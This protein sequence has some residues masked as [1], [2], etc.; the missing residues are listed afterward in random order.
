[1]KKIKIGNRFVGEGEPCFIVA[2]LSAN[3]NGS[4]S[5]AKQIIRLA[6]QA[7]ADAVKIQTY[8]PDTLTLNC[9]NRYF[10][11]K[12]GPWKGQNLYDLYTQAFMPW[13]WQPKLMT[14]ANSLGIMLFSTPFDKSAVD[15]L[16]D[17]LD[18]PAYKIAS[19]EIVDTPLI[20]YAA[21]KKKPMIISTGMADERE[22]QYALDA[23]NR[24]GNRQVVLL[25]CL[26]DYPAKP[27]EMN[28][29]VIPIMKKKFGMPVGLSDHSMFNEVALGA[30]SLGACMIE[31]HFINKRSAGGPDSGFSMEPE[32]FRAMAQSIRILEKSFGKPVIALSPSEQKNR[33][34]RRSLFC[35]KEIKKGEKISHENIKS[36]RPGY[37]LPVYEIKKIIGKRALKNVKVGMPITHHVVGV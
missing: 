30:V 4:I 10:K 34:F 6:K 17:R 12:N 3:H 18:P 19:F 2:E 21:R 25:K 35:V 20:E 27:E 22:I 24:A 13:E 37:G 8:T 29:S 14:Y 7:G 16:S 23:C 15:F 5:R 26:S 11:I 9:N 36:V 32:E 28:L 31:K 33:V 1:M